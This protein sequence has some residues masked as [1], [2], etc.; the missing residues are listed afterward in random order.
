M[1]TVATRAPKRE[2]APDWRDTLRE[3]ARRF[4]VRLA[5]AVLLLLSLGAAVA[6]ATHH[7]TDPSLSTAAAG[8]P[9]NWLGSAGAY[10]SDALLLAFGL[11]S[12]FFLPVIAIAGL[13]MM[14]L[15]PA[16]RVK[17][18]LL[19]A[20]LAAIL[21]GIALGLTSGSAVSGLPGGWG[22][23]VGLAGAY[24]V[25]AALDLIRNPSIAGPARLTA[26]LLFGL[27]GLALAWFALGLAPDERDWLSGLFR[28][29]PL[30]RRA[31]PRAT[32]IR[33]ERVV[34]AAPPKPRPTVAV[35]E[36]ARSVA[37]SYTHLTLP[38]N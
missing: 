26:L 37:V 19:L 1:A 38:T 20:A 8:P 10:V 14:R 22:G 32:E 35:A 4:V 3:S 27:A 29:R 34:P 16:G 15:L 9:E 21:V 23:A 11:G 24:G 6:L 31:A 28:R 17:R 18:S 13:R 12:I 25:D 7:S 30:E 5:G 33:E 36:P 2:L